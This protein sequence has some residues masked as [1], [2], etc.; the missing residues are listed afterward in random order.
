MSRWL[1]QVNSLLEKLDGQVESVAASSQ[2][3]ASLR[4]TLAQQAQ[5]VASA[6]ATVTTTRTSENDDEEYFSEYDDDDQEEEITT[7]DDDEYITEE[8]SNEG[9]ELVEEEELPEEVL[10]FNEPQTELKA[11]PLL[12]S[13]A[14]RSD[15]TVREALMES[16]SPNVV[17]NPSPKSM[18]DT[19]VTRT[20]PPAMPSEP[21]PPQQSKER[22]NS[23]S[24]VD[25]ALQPNAQQLQQQS[26]LQQQIE[27]LKS[28]HTAEMAQL[29]QKNETAM[30][31]VMR[32]NETQCQQLRQQN[33]R[34]TGELQSLQMELKAVNKELQ[35]AAG[36]VERERAA[37]KLER[38]ELLEEQE[39]EVLQMKTEY[40]DKIKELRNEM[41]TMKEQY[42]RQLLKTRQQQSE[43][44]DTMEEQLQQVTER[45][46][47]AQ[48]Q[49][50]QLQTE[51]RQ[52]QAEVQQWHQQNTALQQQY[53]VT[54]E[55][56]TVAEAAVVAAEERLD[57][58]N[59][60]YRK[61]LQQRQARE[62]AL[63]QTVAQL[64]Q[65]TASGAPQN[66]SLI[67]DDERLAQSRV[68][69]EYK[70]QY[71]AAVEELEAM[72]TE[73]AFTTQRCT[74]LEKEFQDIVQERERDVERT[75]QLQQ[76]YDHR[77]QQLMTADQ[78][79]AV[80]SDDAR[81]FNERIQ[82]LTAE[83]RQ[84]NDQIQSLSDQRLRQQTALET[85][86]T[87]LLA[88]KS[89][90]QEANTRAET[91]ES[92]RMNDVELGRPVDAPSHRRRVKGA[93]GGRYSTLPNRSIRMAMGLPRTMARGRGN[94][95]R[96]LQ[97]QLGTT[98]D[99]MDHWMVETGHILRHEPLARLG[100]AI[101]FVMIHLFCFA[102]VAFH[103]IEAEHGDLGQLTNRR[104]GAA[105]YQ[106]IDQ[107]LH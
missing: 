107:G 12:E 71:A 37:M 49:I 10:E 53:D 100:F 46:Q 77:I 23:P 11:E 39:D 65:Q 92:E 18:E 81:Q 78:S 68:V 40:E 83:L 21:N 63:E 9:D 38:N 87:E 88:W 19:P 31:Q 29:L 13:A 85:Q 5:A 24:E 43:L 74:I 96:D 25:V 57:D 89:R 33:D 86:K 58:A 2:P 79:R 97:E 102:M 75:Q 69:A 61:Q 17:A 44:G 93:S 15:P 62:A 95:V 4:S 106:P 91:A 52:L 22:N 7:D 6:V 80:A 59:A 66:S 84:A 51:N 41:T 104:R 50:T 34:M 56:L 42:E 27:R 70:A 32:Q 90:Y 54:M 14:P 98:V 26:L 48:E 28:Q 16:G 99:A 72:K 55:R 105:L 35:E 103:T 101:Y 45:E 60:Q 20:A 82:Q 47:D 8:Q 76:D 36:I 64:S 3:T 73:L 30:Q 1:N 94:Y 67:S